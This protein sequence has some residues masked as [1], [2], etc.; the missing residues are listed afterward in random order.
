MK[1]LSPGIGAWATQG[2]DP[3]ELGYTQVT[4]H[5]PQLPVP[6]SPLWTTARRCR[7]RRS[8]GAE[9]EELKPPECVGWE[10]GEKGAQEFECGSP[11]QRAGQ[12]AVR[13]WGCKLPGDPRSQAVQW[14]AGLPQSQSGQ[15]LLSTW[16]AQLDPRKEETPWED[17]M[18]SGTVWSL[19]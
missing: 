18:K 4:A 10:S 8:Y 17:D 2:C 16:G 13:L 12:R 7:E 11:W 6:G 14:V 19:H 1:Q 5:P 9:E 15:A 3:W